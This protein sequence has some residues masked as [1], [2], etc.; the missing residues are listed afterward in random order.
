MSMFGK[1]FGRK[2][3]AEGQVP[4]RTGYFS[5]DRAAMFDLGLTEDLRRLAANRPEQRDDAWEAAFFSALWNAALV[6]PTNTPFFGPDALIYLRIELPPAGAESFDANSLSN[7]AQSCL[8]AGCGVVLFADAEAA[9]PLYVLPMGVL[10]SLVRYGNWQGDP[11]D[12]DEI[13]GAPV[14]DDDTVPAGSKILTGAP[15]AEYLPP[16]AAAAMDKFMREDAGIEQPMVALMV[17]NELSPSRSLVVNV[18]RED[19]AS[20]EAA[21]QFCQQLLWF[22]P[23]TR[24]VTLWPEGWSGDEFTPLSEL[25]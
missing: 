3:E 24:V 4:V 10:D 16:Y 22:M 17:C 8:D 12:L 11:V 15:S 18:G 6:L 2:N 7:I 25:S 9:E 14:D 23:P 1:L 19:F 21:Q 13:A 20:D 5:V